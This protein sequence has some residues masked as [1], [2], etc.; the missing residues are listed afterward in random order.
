[1]LNASVGYRIFAGKTVHEL[2]LRGRNLTDEKAY[3]H[4]SFLKTAA[5]LPGRDVAVIYR[6]LL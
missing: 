1:M 4:I 6:L 5:P 2:I 3:N